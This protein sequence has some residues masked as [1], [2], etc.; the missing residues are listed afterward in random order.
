MIFGPSS[1]Y[2]FVELLNKL[3]EISFLELL[4]VFPLFRDSLVV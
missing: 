1:V 2:I 4:K 3:V